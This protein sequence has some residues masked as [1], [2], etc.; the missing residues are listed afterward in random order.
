[1]G[2]MTIC[3]YLL[4]FTKTQVCPESFNILLGV[5]HAR[6]RGLRAI[7]FRYKNRG[8]RR[9]KRPP[10]RSLQRSCPL[11]QPRIVILPRPVRRLAFPTLKYEDTDT[12]G[13][14]V[15][16]K[17]EVKEVRCLRVSKKASRNLRASSRWA[18]CRGCVLTGSSTIPVAFSA[19]SRSYLT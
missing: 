17:Y 6:G 2:L 1:M 9:P 10:L 19:C 14:S 8:I 16:E 12:A 15:V 11:H 5:Y 18:L 3:M 13:S 4:M 7:T